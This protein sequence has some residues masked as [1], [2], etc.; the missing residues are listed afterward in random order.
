MFFDTSDITQQKISMEHYREWASEIASS[1]LNAGAIPTNTLQKIAQSE[2][3]LPHQIKLLAAE[4]NKAIH[5][6]KYASAKDKYFAAE[7]PLADANEVINSLQAGQEKVANIFIDPINPL[8]EGPSP[9]EMF[10]IAE[11]V[12]DKTASVRQGLKIMEEKASM[13]NQKLSDAIIVKEA[14]LRFSEKR[15]IKMAREHLLPMDSSIERMKALGGLDH[16]VKVA[17][18]APGKKMLAKLA[19]VLQGEGKLEPR[20]GRIAYEYFSKEAD[21]KA[22][23][24]LISENLTCQVINGEHPLY[25]TLK[26]I[27]DNEADLLRYN[28]ESNIVDDKV[29]ILKQKIRAL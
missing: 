4:A 18:L 19:Y 17:K 11:P 20:H 29:R 25:I 2:D 3:L 6:E 5:T 12:L 23:Q 24:E 9:F 7:F 27:A 21:Q 28:R 16:F 10:G 1:Y 14:Q 15:F 22:P 13:L 8:S 26:T